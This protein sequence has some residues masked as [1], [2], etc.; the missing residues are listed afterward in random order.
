MTAFINSSGTNAEE[1]CKL[2]D[3]LCLTF[4]IMNNSV[5]TSEMLTRED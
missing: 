5:T 1:R 2:R 4:L 3:V